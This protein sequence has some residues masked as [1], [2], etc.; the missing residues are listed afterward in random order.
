MS[1]VEQQAQKGVDDQALEVT[2]MTKMAHQDLH[3]EHGAKK[4]EHAGRS[5]NP[6]IKVHDIA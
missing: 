4:G 5:R 2:P 1:S 3:S 6:V